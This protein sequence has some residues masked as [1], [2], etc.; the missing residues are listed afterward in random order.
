MLSEY[1]SLQYGPMQALGH[2]GFQA[3]GGQ[4]ELIGS[5]AAF[6]GEANATNSFKNAIHLT[7]NW[8][9]PSDSVVQQPG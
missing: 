7:E 1:G 3:A 6:P 4:L 2:K 9:G 8:I 5:G